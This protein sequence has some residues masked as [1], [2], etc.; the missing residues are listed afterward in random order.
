MNSFLITGYDQEK[1]QKQIQVL[2]RKLKAKIIHFSLLKIADVRQLSNLTKLAL[3]EKTAIVIKD[4]DQATEEAQN[5]FLK[6]LEE[7]QEKLFYI[8]TAKSKESPLPTIASRCQVINLK[9]KQKNNK[10]AEDFTQKFLKLSI[11]KK[12]MISSKINLRDEAIDFITNLIYG[13]HGLLINN[14]LQPNDL[15]PFFESANKTLANLQANGNVQ[16]QLTNFI[17]NLAD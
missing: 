6:N 4:I 8:L 7:P 3:S 9:G 1:F 13:G 10:E 14:L 17:V 2:G 5:A 16:L 11:G 12:F 15:L